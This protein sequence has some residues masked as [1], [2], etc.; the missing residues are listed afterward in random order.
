MDTRKKTNETARFIILIPHRD[1]LIQLVKYRE[2]LFSLGFCGAWSFPLAAP[3]AMVSRPF[4]NGELKELARNIRSL[5]KENDGKIH[6]G[7]TAIANCSGKTIINDDKE[8][9]VYMKKEI[10]HLSFF[11]P[12]LNLAVEEAIFPETA[13][14]RVLS[15]FQPLLCV[16]LV[17]QGK[18]QNNAGDAPALSFRAASLANL[19]IRPIRGTEPLS[20]EQPD[21]SFEWEMNPPVWLPAN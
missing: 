5:T 10:E 16:S 1:S 9:N 19:A 7:S 13:K 14:S 18:T 20:T 8:G 15:L 21:Y 17:E 6:S 12:L 4:S 11:G 2:R 3:L